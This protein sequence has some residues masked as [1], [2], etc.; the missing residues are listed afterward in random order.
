MFADASYGTIVFIMFLEL[1]LLIKYLECGYRKRYLIILCG[2]LTLLVSFSLRFPVYIG[3]QL[4]CCL[5][6]LF[7]DKNYNKKYLYSIY[8]NNQK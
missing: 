3:A 8:R 4:I 5:I 6:F 7:Y 2:I 1:V